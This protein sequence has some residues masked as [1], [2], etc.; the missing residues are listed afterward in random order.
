MAASSNTGRAVPLPRQEAKV[1]GSRYMKYMK[2]QQPCASL[3]A[4]GASQHANPLTAPP[5][6]SLHCCCHRWG[7]RCCSRARFCR[8]GGLWSTG[9]PPWRCSEGSESPLI[10]CQICGPCR[11]CPP[12][13]AARLQEVRAAAQGLVA[14]ERHISGTSHAVAGLQPLLDKLTAEQEG[15]A[16]HCATLPAVQEAAHRAVAAATQQLQQQHG[17]R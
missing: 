7:R 12:L 2:Y 16:A 14:L 15:A 1:A 10:T 3:L 8:S 17:S 9:E 5:G 13:P 6:P 11:R 4:A